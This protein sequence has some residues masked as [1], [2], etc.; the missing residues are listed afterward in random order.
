MTSELDM[1]LNAC[2]TEEKIGKLDSV[3]MKNFLPQRTV[4]RK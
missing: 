4:S 3:E 1:T 2:T